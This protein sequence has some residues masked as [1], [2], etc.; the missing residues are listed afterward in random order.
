[1]NNLKILVVDDE[2][3]LLDK[4]LMYV[5]IFCDTVYSA[6]NGKEALEIYEKNKP[7]IILADINMP[8]MNGLELVERIRQTDK[9]T[10]II[11]LTAHT[12][13][14]YLIKSVKLHLISYLLKP[15]KIDELKETITQAIEEISQTNYIDLTGKYQWDSKTKSLLNKDAKIELSDYESLLIKCLID[16]KNKS[17]SYEELHNY[18]YEL[19]EFSKDALSSLVKRIRQKTNKEFIISCYKVGYKING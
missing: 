8:K 7:D 19:E 6:T 5:G 10:K 2:Q 18:I 15:V 14:D 12:N 13:T 4:L 1:M 3:E 17:V 9:K 16:K 11:I